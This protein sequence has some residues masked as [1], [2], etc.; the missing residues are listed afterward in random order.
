MFQPYWI[1]GSGERSAGAPQDG[2]AIDARFAFRVTPLVLGRG[3]P[4]CL[5][6]T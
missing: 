4:N 1:N 2:A 5:G 6:K 3:N